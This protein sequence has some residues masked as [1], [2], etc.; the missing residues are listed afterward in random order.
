[1]HQTHVKTE[2]SRYRSQKC[3]SR[4][5]FITWTPNQKTSVWIGPSKK[6]KKTKWIG[7][8]THQRVVNLTN[9][10]NMIR[11]ISISQ[12]PYFLVCKYPLMQMAQIKLKIITT[13]RC[14]F[15]KPVFYMTRYINFR[16]T[17][18]SRTTIVTKKNEGKNIL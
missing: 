3:S 9:M 2:L 17:Y 15:L 6:K 11:S 7:I 18:L 10:I 4:S 16:V 5:N 12:E 13:K 1:M 14:L 8:F